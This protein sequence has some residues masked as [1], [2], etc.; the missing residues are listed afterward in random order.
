[1]NYLL[2][3]LCYIF[4]ERQSLKNKA[5]LRTVVPKIFYLQSRT[6]RWAKPGQFPSGMVEDGPIKLLEMS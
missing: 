4:M 5:L 3:I 6:L 1:M 2:I